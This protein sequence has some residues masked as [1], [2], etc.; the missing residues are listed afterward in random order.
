[1]SEGQ[2]TLVGEELELSKINLQIAER[3]AELARLDA[4]AEEARTER[5]HTQAVVATVGLVVALAAISR[6][7]PRKRSLM[8]K[9]F[10]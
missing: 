2:V 3:K 4:R 7:R 1:M 9:I 6:P 10:G 5:A 8:Q